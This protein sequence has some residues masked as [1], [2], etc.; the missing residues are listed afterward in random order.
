MINGDHEPN[1]RKVECPKRNLVPTTTIPDTSPEI[2][3][4]MDIAI[5]QD[6]SPRKLPEGTMTT[7][8]TSREIS[9]S[10]GTAIKAARITTEN[11]HWRGVA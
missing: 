3:I 4:R 2:L 8:V 9:T 10:T 5:R 11:R 6:R 7:Q 1:P